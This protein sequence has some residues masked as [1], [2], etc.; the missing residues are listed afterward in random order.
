MGLLFLP[1][2]PSGCLRLLPCPNPEGPPG[3]QHAAHQ[4]HMCCGRPLPTSMVRMVG[5]CLSASSVLRQRL[6]LYT[7]APRRA[8]SRLTKKPMPPWEQPV[9]STTGLEP[10]GTPL[11]EEDEAPPIAPPAVPRTVS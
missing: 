2:E 8:H 6:L 11:P 4:V 10:P 5:M 7:R 9:M 3:W 1:S